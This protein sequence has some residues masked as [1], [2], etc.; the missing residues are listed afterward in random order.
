MYNYFLIF[1]YVHMF[2]YFIVIISF[3]LK[4]LIYIVFNI[5][6]IYFTQ[7]LS[8]A[9]IYKSYFG[10]IFDVFQNY[11]HNNIIIIID[12]NKIL[13]YIYIYYK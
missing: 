2:I 8:K 6:I 10:G 9:L 3:F 4:V 11:Y 13:Y 5:E 7:T 1:Y 12:Y